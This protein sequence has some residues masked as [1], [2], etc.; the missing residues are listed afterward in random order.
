MPVARVSGALAI[1]ELN[2]LA[3]LVGPK[4]YALAR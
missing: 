2:G 1:V 4:T 3:L